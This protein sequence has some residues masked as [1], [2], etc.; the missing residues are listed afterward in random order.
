MNG[1]HNQSDAK[2][3]GL[4]KSNNAQQPIKVCSN[5]ATKTN[6]IQPH[7]KQSV[8]QSKPTEVR[9]RDARG[10]DNMGQRK[11]TM[12]ATNNAIL[13]PIKHHAIYIP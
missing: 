10:R 3:S 6:P 5:S 2:N 8:A 9:E 4:Q 13:D 11:A 1:K 7:R 12:L